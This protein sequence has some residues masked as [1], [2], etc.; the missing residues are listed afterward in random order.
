VGFSEMK[1]EIKKAFMR[2]KNVG[3][4]N[5]YLRFVWNNTQSVTVSTCACWNVT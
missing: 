4:S 5:V 3:I 1:A 2:G